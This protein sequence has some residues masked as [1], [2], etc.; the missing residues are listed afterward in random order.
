MGALVYVV[1]P[2]DLCP[3]AI[4]LIGFL[5]DGAIL[6]AAIKSLKKVIGDYD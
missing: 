6:F 4:P 2:L 1:N 3:D 5:D